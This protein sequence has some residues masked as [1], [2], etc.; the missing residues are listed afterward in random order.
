MQGAFA[1]EELGMSA[2]ALVQNLC[3]HIVSH[4]GLFVR[5]ELTLRSFDQVRDF[6]SLAEQ[7]DDS[8]HP[9]QCLQFC[10]S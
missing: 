4:M 10:V 1:L 9:K 7:K 6:L 5:S 3:V 2:R 8:C